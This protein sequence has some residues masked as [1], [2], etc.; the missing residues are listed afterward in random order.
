MRYLGAVLLCFFLSSCRTDS[1]EPPPPPPP[2]SECPVLLDTPPIGMSTLHCNQNEARPQCEQIVE[3]VRKSCVKRPVLNYLVNGTFGRNPLHMQHDI[4]ELT[5]DGRELTLILYMTNGPGQRR[6]R[7][8]Q[9]PSID[10]KMCPDDFRYNVR[11]NGSFRE[12]LRD[13]AREYQSVIDF[14]KQKGARVIIIPGL[15]DNLNATSFTSLYELYRSVFGNELSYCR[16]PCRS[17]YGGNDGH[18]PS[19]L[20]EEKHASNAN[21]FSITN[22]IVSNDGKTFLFPGEDTGYP[23]AVAISE[24]RSARNKAGQTGNAFI[25]WKAEMQG[26]RGGQLP[27]PAGRRYQVPSES[28][29]GI[30]D[31]FL[32]GN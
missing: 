28:E 13:I 3:V 1:P 4:N 17:C 31:S 19:G 18:I 20:C 5:K 16:N 25:L 23:R 14:A 29:W 15:E 24:L 11:T 32:K 2:P 12:K 6:C 26:L 10:V 7:G 30:I 8:T 9:D 21:A 22:G 27:P